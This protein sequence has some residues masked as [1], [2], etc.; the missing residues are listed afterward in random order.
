MVLQTA[1][2]CLRQ[3]DAGSLETA[4]IWLNKDNA[5]LLNEQ[6]KKEQHSSIS[7]INSLTQSK[8][9]DL[10]T[11]HTRVNY[12]KL[13]KVAFYQLKVIY[14]TLTKAADAQTLVK[15]AAII[16]NIVDFKRESGYIITTDLSDL[17]HGLTELSQSTNY[18]T[19]N[20]EAWLFDISRGKF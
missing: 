12:L 20:Y 17:E 5:E 18:Y 3:V 14:L 16:T 15:L 11:R 4:L 10:V 13:P 6:L 9:L 1:C 2:R 8:P 7:E 19:A